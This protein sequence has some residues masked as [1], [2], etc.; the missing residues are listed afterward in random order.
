MFKLPRKIKHTATINHPKSFEETKILNMD[1]RKWRHILK[2]NFRCRKKEKV[3]V[4]AKALASFSGLR[5]SILFMYLSCH[6]QKQP[7]CM[8]IVD[9]TT[10]IVKTRKKEHWGNTKIRTHHKQ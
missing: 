1:R 9:C 7:I 8:Y 6:P 4:K 2:Q 5:K 10:Q 3:N